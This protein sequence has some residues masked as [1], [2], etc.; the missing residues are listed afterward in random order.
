MNG[1]PLAGRVVVLTGATGN[2]GP[3]VARAFAAAGASLALVARHEPALDSLVASLP[4]G[5]ARAFAVEL[6]DVAAVE[7]LAAD[8]VERL[9]RVDVLLALAGGY[10]PGKLSA[11]VDRRDIETMLDLNLYPAANAIRAFLPRLVANGWGRIVA[12]SALQAREPLARAAPYSASKAALESLVLSA[13]QEVKATGVTANLVVVRSVDT[14]AARAA[15]PKANPA[16]WATPGEIAGALLYL[17]SDESAP[18]NGQRL[19][20]TGRA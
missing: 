3:A 11:E 18:V 5:S 16:T 9:G 13:A 2:V 20:L 7:R 19:T 17:C 1:Q 8:V 6:L 14:P 15:A 4:A 10:R 12:V